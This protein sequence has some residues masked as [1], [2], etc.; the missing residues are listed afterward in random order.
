MQAGR[1]FST[2]IL[3]NGIKNSASELCFA[4]RIFSKCLAYVSPKSYCF[5]LSLEHQTLKLL[6]LQLQY[7]SL[8]YIF[9]FYLF[10]YFFVFLVPHMA[11]GVSQARDQIGAVAAS[12][13]H[14]S[15]QRLILNPLNRARDQ[16]R[17][18]MDPSWV[19]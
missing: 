16:T 8:W 5:Q 11:N 13:H 6:I 12:L 18:L 7:A 1:C 2:F 3:W 10:I 15:W 19:H 14:S 4:L 9:S 17:L